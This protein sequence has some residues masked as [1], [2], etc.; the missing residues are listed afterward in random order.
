MPYERKTV[1]IHISDDLKNVLSVIESESLVAALLLKRRNNRED[2][3]DSY[4]NYISISKQ[5]RTKLSYLNALPHL[6]PNKGLL[7]R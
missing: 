1:D 2:L 4:V 5:D 3:A 7:L 6:W